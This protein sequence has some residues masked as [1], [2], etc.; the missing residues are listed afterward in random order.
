M[1][2]GDRVIVN[3]EYDGLEFNN[4]K[5]VII[6]ETERIF[7]DEDVVFLIEFDEFIA[8]HGFNDGKPGH[9]WWVPEDMIKKENNMKE[10]IKEL[11]KELAALK[12]QLNQKY[13][14]EIGRYFVNG[15]GVIVKADEKCI[16]TDYVQAGRAFN[17][18]KKAEKARDIMVKHDII[19]K[20]VIDHA[21]DYEPTEFECHSVY[22]D[23]E[24]DLW[25]GISVDLETE[26]GTILMP[27]WVAEKLADDLNNN[28][29][30]FK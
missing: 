3:G 6:D 19:L 8:G 4:S 22:L 28:R 15:N 30:D 11:E 23:K 16:L 14:P 17:T 25:Y 29:I 20:Y 7:K 13:E 27:E 10:R 24:E 5:G 12:E 21:P 1:K 26:V 2:I 18:T 9:C